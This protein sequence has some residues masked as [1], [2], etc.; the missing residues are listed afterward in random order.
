MN[1]EIKDLRMMVTNYDKVAIVGHVNPDGD[2]VSSCLGLALCLKKIGI[3]PTVILEPF[4]PKFGI[5][6][7]QDLIYDG[8]IEKLDIEALFCLDCGSIDRLGVTSKLFDKAPVTF[9]IDHH[10]SN[11][12]YAQYNCVNANASSTAEMI[13]DIMNN[14]VPIDC[15]IASAL[16]AGIVYDTGGFRHSCTTADTH[17]TVSKLMWLDIPFSKIYNTIMFERRLSTAKIF[18]KALS[19]LNAENNIYYTFL[20]SNE[21]SDAG[22]TTKEL[23]EIVDYAITIEDADVAVFF[24][25]VSDNNFKASMRSKTIDVSKIAAKFE[26]GGHIHAAGCNV[27]GDI[28]TVIDKILTEVKNAVNNYEK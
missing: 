11:T 19:N 17:I 15:E 23:D 27:L 16:Y 4:N 26:G 5:I 20:T 7:G 9:N 25:Q 2:A 6:P 13:F 28:N 14:L 10:V 12:N 1:I 21:I 3:H 18:G 22:A 8:D 24:Y